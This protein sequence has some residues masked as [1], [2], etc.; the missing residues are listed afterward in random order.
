MTLAAARMRADELDILVD[1]KGYTAGDRLT[2]MA[3]RPCDVQVTWLGYPGTT[4]AAFMDYLIADPF[5]I[6]PG[7]RPR[8]RSASCACRIA[9]SRTI[10]SARRRIR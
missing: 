3:R 1:L 5:V 9:T 8:T 7:G 6:P 4:G 10:A 2:I